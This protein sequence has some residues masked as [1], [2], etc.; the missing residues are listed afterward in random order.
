MT[1]EKG[2][3]FNGRGV[4]FL[5]NECTGSGRHGGKKVTRSCGSRRGKVDAFHPFE[6]NR[7][8]GGR[9]SQA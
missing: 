5:N 2:N 3:P 1:Y 4:G 7:G 8:G 9:K 6:E